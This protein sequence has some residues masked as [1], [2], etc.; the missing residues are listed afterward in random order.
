MNRS[1]F[2]AFAPATPSLEI[3]LKRGFLGVALVVFG[4]TF[5]K[6]FRLPNLWVATHVAFNYSQGFVRRGLVGE[7]ARLVG[8]VEV[9]RYKVIVCV[10]FLVMGLVGIAFTLAI[11]RAL[12]TNPFDWSLRIALLVFLSSPGLVFFVHA[13]GYND[14]YGLLMSLLWVLLASRTSRRFLPVVALLAIGGVMAFIHEAL[15]VMFGP[16][17]LFSLACHLTG[18]SNC[19]APN[20]RRCAFFRLCGSPGADSF[21]AFESS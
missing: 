10:A 6:G 2:R 17:L 9:Y 3:S 4:L 20:Q 12:K 8:G 7:V 15:F 11:R 18:R 13:V 19:Q 5:F 1:R 21:W 16:M 14:Y